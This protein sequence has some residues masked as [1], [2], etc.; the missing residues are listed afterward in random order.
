M[1]KILLLGIVSLLLIL[2]GLCTADNQTMDWSYEIQKDGS[3]MITAYTGTG[4]EVTIPEMLDGHPVT[5]LAHDVFWFNEEI[6][7]VAI[8]GGLTSIQDYAYGDDSLYAS[9]KP[10]ML[11]PD[12]ARLFTD[13]FAAI[14]KE[15]QINPFLGCQNLEA[16]TVSSENPVFEV[17]DGLLINKAENKTVAYPA[18]RPGGTYEIREGITS[19][20]FQTFFG[21][22]LTS[23]TL[24][25][26][27]NDINL[28]P[29]IFCP[30]LSEI[31]V[32]AENEFFE[33]Q[34][35]ALINKDGVLLAHPGNADAESYEIPEGVTSIGA[36]AFINNQHLRSVSIPGTAEEIGFRAFDYNFKLET[37]SLQDGVRSISA[38]AFRNC[39][40]LKEINLPKSISYIADD[41]FLNIGRR[42]VFT[43]EKESYGELW[44]KVYS[45]RFHFPDE[46][47]QKSR[48]TKVYESLQDENGKISKMHLNY[49][50]ERM[51]N[52]WWQTRDIYIAPGI[53]YV[54]D[55]SNTDGT[56]VTLYKDGVRFVLNPEEKT[57]TGIKDEHWFLEMDGVINEVENFINIFTGH[58]Y[59]NDYVDVT[60]Y[61]G[62]K[63]YKAEVFAENRYNPEIAFYF[64]EDGSLV[65][66][67]EEKYY[68]ISPAGYGKGEILFTINTLEKNFDES[69]FDIS[70][71][72]ITELPE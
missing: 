14:V 43:V 10:D 60:R 24:P 64:D 41:A 65:Y 72:E 2:T 71:Y 31:L 7:S 55:E 29:F 62:D 50:A 51:V 4:G 70:D 36:G 40:S 58:T 32:S 66:C 19:I 69:V 46:P 34:D 57:G 42:L 6:T 28:N 54:F 18:G 33:I 53:I 44:A 12:V 27:M 37:V 9:R 45:Y 25:A 67:Y 21:S 35:H 61:L 56:E 63:V 11:D 15:T 13:E 49:R 68:G 17:S 5:G 59:R 16:I 47:E 20:G 39:E 30:E 23:V 38:S 22:R 26:S 52:G 3:A 48:L 8:P 1:K